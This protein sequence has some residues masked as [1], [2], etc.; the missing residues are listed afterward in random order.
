MLSGTAILGRW[1]VDL[2][3][4]YLNGTKVETSSAST[5]AHGVAV[6]GRLDWFDLLDSGR[7]A[8]SPFISYSWSRIA[9]DA[10]SETGGAFPIAMNRS[11]D[12]SSEGRLGI[13]NRIALGTGTGTSLRLSGEY[14]HRFDPN[15]GGTSFQII[16]TGLAAG[17]AS[18]RVDRDNGRV[19]AELDQ[20]IGRNGLFSI[21]AHRT[22]GN[23]LGNPFSL[24]ATLRF[25]L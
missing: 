10:Y 3:R 22:V 5:D 7:F 11:T 25:G 8:L 12:T 17:T 20:A 2:D 14:I 18:Y 1:N 19:G 13:V 4:N 24:S 9:I 21:A 15:D 16:G 23:A 6:R